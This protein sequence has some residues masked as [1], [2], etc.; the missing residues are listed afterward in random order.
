MRKLRT[1][2]WISIAFLG[3]LGLVLL[4]LVLAYGEL[5]HLWSKHEHKKIK[6]RDKIISYTSQDIPADPINLR[7]VG[8][9][10]SVRCAFARAG[11]SLA[12]RLSAR[13]AVGIVASVVLQRPYSAAPVSSLYFQERL[14]DLA[15]E[16]DEGRSAH[17]RHHVRLWQLGP[18][19]WLGAATYDRGVGLALFTLEVTHHI[20][21]NIDSERD[22]LGTMLQKAGATFEG[23]F[24]SRVPPNVRQRNGGGDSYFTDGMIKSYQLP[25][26]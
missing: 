10:K 19:Q 15:F 4:W 1:W 11:W 7:L 14:Q 24:P 20:G 5:P 16:K 3:I 12:D 26:C 2:H 6:P 8:D 21:P 13:S 18:S 22:S 23:A 9:D 17:R 25:K